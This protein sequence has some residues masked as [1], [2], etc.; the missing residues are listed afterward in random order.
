MTTRFHSLAWL[1]WALA[2][3]AA[4]QVAPSALYVA[5]V[6]LVA[7]LVVEVHGR[8]TRLARTFPFFVTLGALFG[9]AR[10]VIAVLT[11][12]GA[13]QVLFTLPGFTMPRLLGGFGVGG[14]IELEVLLQATSEAFVIVAMIAVFGAWNAVVSHDEVLQSVPRAFHELGLT[15]SV[16]LAFVPSTL[17]SVS[18]TR[19][20]DRARTGGAVVRR[21]LLVRVV[22]PVLERGLERAVA[23]AESMD[24]RGFGHLPPGPT[25]ATAAWCGL[26]ALAALGG[27]FAALVGRAAMTANVLGGVGIVLTVAAVALASRASRRVRHRA[28]RM[29]QA[30]WAMAAVSAVAP[31]AIALL[32]LGGDRTLTWEPGRLQTPGF[33]P[34]VALALL[35]LAAPAALPPRGAPA[36]APSVAKALA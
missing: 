18:A 25:E 21:G 29:S 28:R 33:N 36:P 34:L 4:L 31:A 14:T 35:A 1:A 13:G 27:A 11:T 5:V 26:A 12:H 9:L 6:L 8:Q 19:E 32:A 7:V 30:D 10:V 16:A 22:V 17:A 15:V 23:L 2:A 24:S 20:A 3:V